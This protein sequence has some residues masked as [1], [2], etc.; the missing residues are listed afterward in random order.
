VQKI[1]SA[2]KRHGVSQVVI[3]GGVACNSRFREKMT[4]AYFPPPR[5]CAD[6]AAMVACLSA[7]YRRQGKLKPE[8]WETTATATS[9]LPIAD[10][11]KHCASDAG[12][13]IASL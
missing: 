9:H 1:R 8:G 7:I 2:Q 12:P 11:V 4:D 13:P 10:L 6:N 3:T 5:H